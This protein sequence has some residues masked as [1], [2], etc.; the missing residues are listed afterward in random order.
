MSKA[1]TTRVGKIQA[2]VSERSSVRHLGWRASAVE[3]VAVVVRD[4]CA[5]ETNAKRTP[6]F[7]PTTHLIQL[8]RH[9]LCL[10]AS[11][12]SSHEKPRRG[13]KTSPHASSP[14]TAADCTCARSPFLL[15]SLRLEDRSRFT[16]ELLDRLRGRKQADGASLAEMETELTNNL[17]SVDLSVCLSVSL[18]LSDTLTLIKIKY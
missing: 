9:H 2:D 18:S 3:A 7:C 12:S 4:S 8:V 10:R 11:R 16:E 5:R 14:L 6:D 17:R 1:W 15:R 13:T